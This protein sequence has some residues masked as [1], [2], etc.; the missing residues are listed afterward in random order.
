MIWP[1]L[2]VGL[3]VALLV[4]IVI[5]KPVR[6]FFLDVVAAFGGPLLF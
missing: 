6:E 4:A 5:S 1:F 3:L 2:L